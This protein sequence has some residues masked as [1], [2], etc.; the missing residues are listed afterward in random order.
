MS[1]N[2]DFVECNYINS[3]F[4]IKVKTALPNNDEEWNSFMTHLANFYMACDKGTFKFGLLVDIRNLGMLQMKYYKEFINFFDN[5]KHI[6]EK[7]LIATSIVS[8]NSV[9]INII[10]GFLMLYD[11]VKPLKI[12]DSEDKAVEFINKNKN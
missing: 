5:N 6:T 9:L 3:N 4:T 10:N 7:H 8:S 1:F 11:T 2:N 12:V